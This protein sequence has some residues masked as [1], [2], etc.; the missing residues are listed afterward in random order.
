VIY[1]GVVVTM[2]FHP[3]LRQ[4]DERLPQGAAD[5]SSGQDRAVPV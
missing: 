3:V 4:M 2:W 1:I 5:F